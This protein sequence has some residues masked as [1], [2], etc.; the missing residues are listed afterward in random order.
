MYVAAAAVVDSRPR[1]SACALLLQVRTLRASA[2][3]SALRFP[4]HW[5]S[6]G[7]LVLEQPSLLMCYALCGYRHAA[8]LRSQWC[9]CNTGVFTFLATAIVAGLM[10]FWMR[11]SY[12]KREQF[13]RS[14]ELYAQQS[15][16]QIPPSS[17]I[18][19]GSASVY[20]DGPALTVRAPP[21]TDPPD[22]Q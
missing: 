12:K 13:R 10:L 21:H 2:A 11:H 7:M 15:S 14:P 4:A 9:L 5:C 3:L 19:R 8:R 18:G 16:V 22:E 6:G 17:P 1:R 20:H